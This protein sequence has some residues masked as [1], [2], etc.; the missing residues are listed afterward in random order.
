MPLFVA[1]VIS[2]P[3]SSFIYGFT[4]EVV[5]PSGGPE[6]VGSLSHLTNT[7]QDVLSYSSADEGQF[8]P[9]QVA[10]GKLFQ[11]RSRDD[12]KGVASKLSGSPRPSRLAL[13]RRNDPT[14][15]RS[16]ESLVS[17]QPLFPSPR[18]EKKSSPFLPNVVKSPM[19]TYVVKSPMG[20]YV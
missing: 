6:K 14:I 18:Q 13:H 19:G 7:E 9:A 11:E 3:V 16:F 12:G 4:N 2:N 17:E 10:M 20:M 8:Q 5:F 1:M 15:S